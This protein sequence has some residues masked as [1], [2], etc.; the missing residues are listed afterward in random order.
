MKKRLQHRGQIVDVVLRS[1]SFALALT[2]LLLPPPRA[3]AQIF[4][5]LYTFM[6]GTDGSNPSVGLIR[7][8]EGNLYGTTRAGGGPNCSGGCGTVFKLDTTGKLT[9]LHSFTGRGDGRNP[10]AGLIRDGSGNLYGTAFSGGASKLGTV[11]E[12]DAAGKQTVLHNFLGTDGANPAASLI[13]GAEGNLYGTAQ[14][15]GAFKRGTVFKLKPSTTGDVTVL[16]TLLVGWTGETPRQVCS[17][18]RRETSTVLRSSGAPPMLERFLSWM[19]MATKLCCTASM[20][21][22]VKAPTRV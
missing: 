13:R 14:R 9:L 10:F 5:V 15:G 17:G 11:F 4:T 1:A 22:M 2:V 19:Q 7:D 12:V 21:Q 20:G 18:T 16:H 6:G 3:Q 8:A